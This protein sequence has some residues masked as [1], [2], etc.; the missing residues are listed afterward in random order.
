VDCGRVGKA[1]RPEAHI[2]GNYVHLRAAVRDNGVD[3]NTVV[4][5]EG[6]AQGIDGHKSD[7]GGVEGIDYLVRHAASMGSPTARP[8]RGLSPSFRKTS[9]TTR[10]VFT[11]LNPRFGGQLPPKPAASNSHWSARYSP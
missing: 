7:L 2:G 6:L 8:A 9:S 4:I 3:A 11:S 1:N 10:V 5:T